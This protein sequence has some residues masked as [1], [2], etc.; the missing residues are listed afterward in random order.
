[1]NVVGRPGFYDF[2]GNEAP[3]AWV[4]LL[5]AFLR[6]SW[7]M[8][9]ACAA[10]AVLLGAM[11][12]MLATPKFTATTQL[13]IDTR[14]GN[15]FQQQQPSASLDSLADNAI[16]DSQ[17]EVLRSDGTARHV[18]AQLRLTQDREFLS[19]N[20][21]GIS[22]RAWLS[23]L[24]GLIEPP[25]P[26]SALPEDDASQATE[27]LQGMAGIRRIGL[28]NVIEVAV[29]SP[30]PTRSAQLAN[31]LTAAY[32]DD[33]LR[34]KYD[35]TRQAAAWL[36]DRLK[37]LRDQSTAAD[38]A[39]QEQK[40]R[41]GLVDTDKGG[42]NEQALG[43]LTLQLGHARARS[44]ET[45]ARYS[46]IQAITAA[47]LTSSGS[48]VDALANA[49]ILKLQQQYLDD[50]RRLVEWTA[51]YG[52][53]HAA[54]LNLGR[55]MAGLRASLGDELQRIQETYKSDHDVARG[56]EAALQRQ[57]DGL[58]AVSTATNGA[59][60][61]IRS[62]ESLADTYRALYG[63][64]LQRYTQAAQDQS[65]PIS[66]A[67]TIS[68]ATPPLRKSAPATGLVMLGAAVAGLGLGVAGSLVR[69]V[70]DRRFR[71][72]AQVAEVTGL[73]CIGVLPR[74]DRKCREMAAPVSP[75]MVPS[76][77]ARL[78]A[79]VDRPRSPFAQAVRRLRMRATN[80]GG[81]LPGVIGIVSAAA[82]EGR[83][84]L[85]ANL[86]Q[87]MAAS[88]QRTILIDGD[89]R[90]PQLTRWMAPG[91]VSDAS[92]RGMALAGA[93]IWRD[94]AT[95]LAFLPVSA[96]EPQGLQAVM[97][98]VRADFDRVVI[99]L[100]ALASLAD[101]P[102]ARFA[103][104]FIVLVEWSRTQQQTLVDGLEAADIDAGRL[105]GVVLTKVDLRALR[106]LSTPG[107]YRALAGAPGV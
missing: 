22:P 95:G 77:P 33:T 87:E 41:I 42:M 63:S 99:D 58:V 8:I 70:T 9:L 40:A 84:T 16:V 32:I 88:G 15:A 1:M 46:R 20:G 64:F 54:V 30:S 66:Q 104:G 12:A 79:A 60:A 3:F 100:P 80:S 85:A 56:N 4:P 73:E 44:A 75:G 19:W 51:R 53:R 103:D 2:D 74:L 68:P 83:S 97:D 71:T 14:Q 26:R 25:A 59:R 18:V 101:A 102:L 23:R 69:E 94:A 17:V 106:R 65:F 31:A 37:E 7:R 55:E 98:A 27:R 61:Q 10:A 62:L 47:G 82:G 21:S 105:L 48:V 28:S 49:I 13:L 52:A 39:L 50:A 38:R 57:V 6:R 90:K 96:V 91:G 45:A 81:R 43:D 93:M 5:L 36:Q 67:R 34:A 86:A 72:A 24:A 78:R 29:Q 107:R 92:A 11:Y 76:A 35:I 89:W